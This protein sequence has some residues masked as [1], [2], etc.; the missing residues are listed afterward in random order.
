VS[1]HGVAIRTVG[2][3][4]LFG[5]GI[6]A[7]A[8][9]SGPGALFKKKLAEMDSAVVGCFTNSFTLSRAECHRLGELIRL[10][11]KAYLTDREDFLSTLKSSL[12]GVVDAASYRYAPI[13][14]AVLS[15][16]KGLVPSL[17]RI[18]SMEAKA[19]VRYEYGKKALERMKN[20]QCSAVDD[21][22]YSEICEYE[23]Q[24]FK[25]AHELQDGGGK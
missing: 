5:V 6:S 14:L 8:A 1:F 23:D 7:E 15:R 21:P 11:R 13:L 9:S 24:L 16:E 12:G 17:E 3:I 2:V 4:L 22:N 10:G 18:A 20:G 19:H 25:R